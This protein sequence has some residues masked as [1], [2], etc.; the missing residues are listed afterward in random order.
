[1]PR[2][3]PLVFAVIIITLMLLIQTRSEHFSFAPQPTIT[4]TSSSFSIAQISDT[5]YLSQEY[6][7]L[8]SDTVNWIVTN[9]Y[10]YNIQM[11]I[12]TGDII[13]RCLDTQQW[14][15]ANTAMQSL[16]TNGIP[17]TWDAGNHDQEPCKVIGG[18]SP[19]NPWIGINYPAF[20]PEN[21]RSRPYW[22]SDLFQGKNTAVQF[23]Y[24]ARTFLI[25]NL[26]YEANSTALSWMM[27][28]IETHPN[29]RVI[30]AT[31]DYIDSHCVP[32]QV[33]GEQVR[34]ILNRYPQVVLTMNG[35][36]TGECHQQVGFREETMFDLQGDHNQKGSAA[37][38]LFTFNGNQVT[39]S[40]FSLCDNSWLPDSF[41]FTVP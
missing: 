14:T 29:D 36:Y 22:V 10:Q 38:R 23:T 25:I 3:E 27:H 37:V 39:V 6:P 5:Q 40:T 2:S 33:F 28:L 24:G 18:G 13:D 35:H 9:R 8:Y 21:M 1:M 11:V 16:T 17:Y 19:M 15:N 34:T 41:T 32:S 7:A 12:H 4:N 30:L 20:N 31:H 26:E